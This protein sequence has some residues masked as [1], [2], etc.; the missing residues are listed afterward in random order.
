MNRKRTTIII[1]ILFTGLF[2]LIPIAKATEAT[3]SIQESEDDVW[4]T[5]SGNIFGFEAS[6]RMLDPEIGIRSFLRF[7]DV[8]L[9]KAS[10]INLA[11]LNVYAGFD[12]GETISPG[13]SV[14]IYGI[15]EPD[16]APFSY[17]GQVW[18]LERPYTS[19][20]VN[21]N[22][23]DW[24]Q[25][26][27]QAVNV[28]SIVREIINQYAW[29]QNNAIGFQILGAS[30]SGYEYRTFEDIDHQHHGAYAYLY[31]QYDVAPGTPPGLPDTS[32]WVETYGE[33]DIWADEIKANMSIFFDDYDATAEFYHTTYQRGEA[34]GTDWDHFLSTGNYRTPQGYADIITQVN[35]T[36]IIMLDIGQVWLYHTNDGGA[37][38]D[39]MVLN[40]QY[41]D[42]APYSVSSIGSMSVDLNGTIHMTWGTYTP[43]SPGAEVAVYSNFTVDNSGN[44]VFYDGFK[45]WDFNMDHENIESDRY[46]RI[47]FS[48]IHNGDLKYIMRFINSTWY[49][50]ETIEDQETLV[51]T[52]IDVADMPGDFP[53]ARFVYAKKW[54]GINDIYQTIRDPDGSLTDT[55]LEGTNTFGPASA[56]DMDGNVSW[57]VWHDNPDPRT[58][59]RIELRGYNFSSLTL[60]AKQ[61]VSSIDQQHQRPDIGIGVDGYAYI[62]WWSQWYPL[63][64]GRRMDLNGTLVGSQ[65]GIMSSGAQALYTQIVPFMGADYAWIDYFITDENGTVIDTWTLGDDNFTDIDDLKDFVDDIINPQG[66]DPLDPAPGSGWEETGPFTR[67]KMRLYFLIIGLGCIFGPI[68]AMAYKKMDSVGYA[69]CALIMILGTGLLWS[70]TG[71]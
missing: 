44:L 40:D 5:E 34:D 43:T 1:L 17:G 7:E 60:L 52:N 39:S 70:I 71:I 23:S 15:D 54:V 31:L 62:L 21:W 46:G 58:H 26:T 28:T 48:Y 41:T 37:S 16:C 38:W 35:G 67:F 29:T 61:A 4:M 55:I 57:A 25:V 51:E 19:A 13:A 6:V 24:H 42:L 53:R 11:T 63:Y 10:K 59:P 64:M 49:G 45:E 22:V 65:T 18:S 9:L 3:V 68:W 36:T 12:Q 56:M 69:W 27:W 2:P 47:H 33:Y 30:D 14:T 8:P 20:S 50:P 32:T 66:G